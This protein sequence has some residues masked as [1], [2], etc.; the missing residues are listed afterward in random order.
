[1]IPEYPRFRDLE[2]DDKPFFDLAFRQALPDNS[3]FT[4]TNLFSWRRAYGFQVSRLNAF[5]L[6]RSVKGFMEPIGPGDPAMRVQSM[7]RVLDEVPEPFIRVHEKTAVLLEQTPGV[8]VAQDRDNFDYLYR[9]VD[10][11]LLAGR[12]YDGKRNQIRKFKSSQAYVYMALDQ[13]RA[14]ECLD[15]EEEW[16]QE[17]SCDKDQGLEH[18]RQAIRD[19]LENF[20][21]FSL[22]GGAIR[23][24]GKMVALALAE[25]L[26]PQTLVMHVMKAM[27]DLPGLYQVMYQEFLQSVAADYP[28]VNAEQDLGI[29]GL[30]Q[31]KESYHPF[32]LIPKFVLE[33]H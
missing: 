3:E 11:T 8:K 26:N 2:L 4:F 16:C 30:R 13:A 27:P 12:K 17:R 9:T 23:V 5:L 24:D 29:P 7:L 6:L 21:R 10:L 31:S 1:M 32:Q 20:E 22:S 25:A 15:F 33:R 28:F 19:M 14:R 18:E